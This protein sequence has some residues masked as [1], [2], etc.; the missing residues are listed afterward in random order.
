MAHFFEKRDYWGNGYGMWVLVA[1]AFLTPLALWSCEQIHLENRVENWLPQ[2]DPQARTLDWTHEYFPQQERVLI[3]WDDSSLWDPRLSRLKEK[4]KGSGDNEK[5]PEIEGVVAPEDIFDRMLEGGVAPETALDRL[6]GVLI[7]RGPL[8]VRLSAEAR[9]RQSEIREELA[10][11]AREELHLAV[12]IL[13]PC[14]SPKPA[15]KTSSESEPS[16]PVELADLARPAPHDFA[17]RWPD[18]NTGHDVEPQ[19]IELIR[20]LGE[21][22]DVEQVF[23]QPGTPAALG[24][25]ISY[26]GRRQMPQTLAAIYRCADEVGIPREQL[27]IAGGPVVGNELNQ[28]VRK[29]FWNPDYPAYLLHKRSPLLFSSLVGML[30]AFVMLR[31]ARLAILVLITAN[32]TVLVTVA[33][34]PLTQGSMNMVLVCMPTLLSVLTLSGA[35]HVANYWKYAAIHD[36]KRAIV[37]TCQM[38]R[39]PCALASITTAVGLMSLTTSNL[40]PVRDFGF[41]AAIGCLIS[42]AV[43]LYGLPAMLQ[44]WPGRVPE[45]TEADHRRWKSVAYFLTDNWKAVTAASIMIY[46][47]CSIGLTEFRTETKV[48]RYLSED[49]PVV[50]DYHFLEEQLSGIVP[51]D[52]LVR[53]DQEA[54]QRLSFAERRDVIAN[55]SQEIR[56]HPEISGTMSLADFVDFHFPTPEP[57]EPQA[58]FNPEL[59]KASRRMYEAEK[60]LKSGE[61]AGAKSLF[62]VVREPKRLE[63]LGG[64]TFLVE[65]G[66]ELWRVTAQVAIM[67]DLDYAELTGDWA[68]PAEKPGELN[69]IVEGI[70][71]DEPGTA[72]L[73]TGMVPLLLQTQQA[74]LSS[75]IVSF[76][77]A[78]VLIALIMIYLLRHPVSG[79]LSMIPNVLPIGM[80]FGLISWAG[81]SVD[82]GTMITA[83]VAL[84]IAVDGT[85]HLLTWFRKG[86]LDGLSRRNAIAQA[87]MHCGPALWQTTAAVGF[88]LLMLYCADLLLVSRFGWLMATLIVAALIADLILFPA[89][90]AGPL[91]TI[92]E[93]TLTEPVPETEPLPAA[94]PLPSPDLAPQHG[95][96]A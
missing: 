55:I 74:V 31:S 89:L 29:V 23:F 33:L 90:L 75:L 10:R 37:S 20:S 49:R 76:G 93:R 69:A 95:H 6:T 1:M 3:S 5:F 92:I 51:V 36:P 82:I 77:L 60:R 81:I 4:L 8:R 45:C 87:L 28:G 64:Q 19:V 66:D 42:L 14:E 57:G 48:I 80:V 96:L 25:G 26:A 63:K 68:A 73:V 27:R 47:V 71:A 83:S 13:A 46:A 91:G 62:A 38:A 39:K 30:L 16:A 72:H 84:G 34:V 67:S 17:V 41:Y 52:V 86:L 2:D 24:V 70:L 53:F 9:S 59:A 44:F 35:I 88:G 21:S 54:Q 85:L 12:E 32:F 79:L 50:E 11:R 78:F 61:I 56:Q 58:G 40:A 43:V 7:G 94:P 18:R 15:A 22:G 65:P